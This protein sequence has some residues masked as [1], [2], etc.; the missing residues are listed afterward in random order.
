VYDALALG[1]TLAAYQHAW[2]AGEWKQAAKRRFARAI[3]R[4][5]GEI[6]VVS[7]EKLAHDVV[8]LA[9][10]VG[11]RLTTLAAPDGEAGISDPERGRTAPREKP[12]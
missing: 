8:L 1:D 3:E 12:A 11:G 6:Q 2:R 5:E 7:G 4:D 10:R 9:A